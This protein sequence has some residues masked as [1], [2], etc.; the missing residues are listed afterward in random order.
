MAKLNPDRTTTKTVNKEGGPAY[1]LPLRERFVSALL[2]SLW[3]EPKFY[4]DNTPQLQ[5]DI[6]NMVVGKDREFVAQAA[7]YA[8]ETM[9]L[10]TV[11]IVVLAYLALHGQQFGKPY[12][13]EAMERIVTRADQIRELVAAVNSLEPGAAKKLKQLKLGLAD[14][15]GIF[16]EY[17]LAKYNGGKGTVT[18]RDCLL[19]CHPRPENEERS[20][21]YER[22]LEGK[23]ATPKTWET[24]ISAKGNTA[25]A[26]DSLIAEN[27]LPYMAA[28][29]NLRNLI[30]SG[31]TKLPEVLT[32]LA[33]PKRVAKS[34]QFPFRFYAAYKVLQG[35]GESNVRTAMHAV[36]S[37]LQSSVANIPMLS[38]R[39]AV[40]VDESGSMH[41]AL[42]QKSSMRYVD[43]GNVLAAIVSQRNTDTVVIPFGEIAKIVNTLPGEPILTAAD[44]FENAGVGH[45]TNAYLA[46]RQMIRESIKV[47]RIVLLS[48]E[49]LWDSNR[50]GGNFAEEVA[51]Y[52]KTIN[53][54][55]WIHSIDLAGYGTTPISIR[56]K[57]V[58]LY[59]GWSEKILSILSQTE[60]GTGGMIK[61]IETIRL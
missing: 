54:D 14:A 44:K 46:V 39:T 13:R 31:A 26:W 6:A 9:N 57:R 8:R 22:L 41:S 32:M 20:A 55:V 24:E 59:A 5:E 40:L 29:R 28:L 42:S 25:E 17:Q 56:D 45:S 60:A 49:Q 19:I 7:V 10:R 36:E 38:G 4:G 47:D 18:L 35:L 37:A 53:P 23:M 52:R 61:D 1:K 58:A 21:L 3:A 51:T 2:T 34:K 12:F 33:D 27:K 43:A 15:F 16:N 48:D 50:S 11:P 30:Q